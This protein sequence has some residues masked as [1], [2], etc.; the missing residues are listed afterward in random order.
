M[1][2]LMIEG[3]PFLEAYN[4]SM[5]DGPTSWMKRVLKFVIFEDPPSKFKLCTVCKAPPFFTLTCR[6]KENNSTMT[7]IFVVLDL[8][9]DVCAR[10]VSKA[11]P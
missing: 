4:P 8:L 3:I 6:L 7:Y 2:L 10:N 11:S 9:V 5:Q 1:D